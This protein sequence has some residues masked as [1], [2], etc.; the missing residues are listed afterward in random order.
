MKKLV[1][2]IDILTLKE[3]EEILK[4][5]HQEDLLNLFKKEYKPVYKH[6]NQRKIPLDQQ[7]SITIDKDEK[8]MIQGELK[9]IAQI[10][11]AISLSA[12]IR[13]RTVLDV[14]IADWKNCAL[15]G[16]KEFADG[17]WD[18]K[19]INRKKAKYVK[20]LDDV[21]DDSEDA[22]FYKKHIER[23]NEK[24]EILKRKISKRSFRINSRVSYTE[25]NLIRWRAARL[26][27]PIAD[28]MRFAL[29]GYTP[30]SDA[31]S[32]FSVDARKRFYISILDVA[33]NGWGSPPETID[34]PNIARYIDEIKTLKEKIR[35]YETFIKEK[36]L[37]YD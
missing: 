25:A 11:P 22:Y 5:L 20:L 36:G 19:I 26:N 9:A 2:D 28:Y 3:K 15:L 17:E 31:D 35:R 21:E 14:D 4:G 29:F 27:I 1:G 10:G 30:F 23:Y 13:N 8:A 34:D 33:K 18:S 32:H 6:V 24:L 37:T 7:I 12:F 16:L